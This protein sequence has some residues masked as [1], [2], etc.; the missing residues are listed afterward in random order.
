MVV[1]DFKFHGGWYRSTFDVNVEVAM[2]TTVTVLLRIN[3]FADFAFAV[4]VRKFFVLIS[5]WAK[6]NKRMFWVQG[7]VQPKG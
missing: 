5:P 4:F 6:E 1:V 2:G 7:M 3:F